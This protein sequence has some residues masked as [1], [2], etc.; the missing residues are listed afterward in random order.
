[1]APRASERRRHALETHGH[2]S[3]AGAEIGAACDLET[4]DDAE[5]SAVT[6]GQSGMPERGHR[7]ALIA[8]GAS[9][10][11]ASRLKVHRDERAR[12]PDRSTEGQDQRMAGLDL[13]A[14]IVI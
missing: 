2:W 5:R 11:P 9:E 12:C 14:A 7:H 3:S 4:A 6:G 13:F 8:E 1:M 10:A